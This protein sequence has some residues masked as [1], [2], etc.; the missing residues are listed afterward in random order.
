VAHVADSI[1][2]HRAG[3]TVEISGVSRQARS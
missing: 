2:E 3:G 1:N